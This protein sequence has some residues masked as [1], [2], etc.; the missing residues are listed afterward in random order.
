AAQIMA[1][2]EGV[3]VSMLFGPSESLILADDSADPTILAADYL[4]EA[5]HG[6]DSAAILV[7]PS[8]QLV[9]AVQREVEAQLAALPE[10]RRS[11]AESATTKYG[12]AIIVRDLAEGIAFAN[13][14]A[15]EHLQV[16]ARDPFFVLGKL[17]NAGEILL[18]QNTAIAAAN[19]VI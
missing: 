4:N 12:G 15:A 13:E 11:Y 6:H 7:T 14:Y 3:E 2:L 9:A 10:P 17:E 18:G 1:Q 5:E 16:A 8:R 19:F